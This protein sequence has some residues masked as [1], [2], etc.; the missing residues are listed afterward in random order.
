MIK[1]FLARCS[2]FS[3]SYKIKIQPP[4]DSIDDDIKSNNYLEICK[5]DLEKEMENILTRFNNQSEMEIS[6]QIQ[7]NQEVQ[8][9]RK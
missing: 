3:S 2:N 8:Q 5:A 7:E 9:M 6:I 1:D 4:F